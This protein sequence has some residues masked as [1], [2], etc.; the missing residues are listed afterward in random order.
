MKRDFSILILL[1]FV[2]LF[3][4]SYAQTS[5]QEKRTEKKPT[6]VIVMP[7]F[8]N[9][10]YPYVSDEIR[11]YLMWGFFQRDFYV[12]SDDSSWSKVLSFNYQLSNLS[13]EMA[14]SISATVEADLIIYGTVN[15]TV[16]YRPG[17]I[18]TNPYVPNPILIKAYDRKK[19]SVVLFERMDFVERWGLFV[20]NISLLD[21]GFRIATKLSWLGY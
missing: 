10:R 19:K 3:C 7:F 4:N 5:S 12:I 1:L 2:S 6:S 20:N 13:T 16:K 21:F 18:Y 15:S 9:E 11:Q 14:D 17:G 8:V